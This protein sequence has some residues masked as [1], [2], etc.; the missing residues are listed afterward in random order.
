MIDIM[1]K[2][3]V[4]IASA[5]LLVLVFV[6]IALFTGMFSFGGGSPTGG[7][8]S[9]DTNIRILNEVRPTD[10]IVYGEQVE[11]RPH[12]VH[13]KVGNLSRE[14]LT[15][16]S[17]KYKHKAIVISD[18]D[19]TVALTQADYATILQLIQEEG[20]FFLYIGRAKFQALRD[21]GFEREED[22]GMPWSPWAK[23]DSTTR[24]A[25]IAAAMGGYPLRLGIRSLASGDPTQDLEAMWRQYSFALGNSIIMD[26]ASYVVDLY[27]QNLPRT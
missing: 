14:S 10:V 9:V 26:I 25:G 27:R 5:V 17:D 16:N 18:L 15:L 20:Y 4:L 7:M 11:F 19:G 1:S 24:W 21:N 3:I 13:R 6:F 2:K 8:D 12:F 23:L 22:K